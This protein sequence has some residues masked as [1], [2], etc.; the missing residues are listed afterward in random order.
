MSDTEI[1]SCML[2]SDVAMFPYPNNRGDEIMSFQSHDVKD[3]FFSFRDFC[4]LASLVNR[5]NCTNLVDSSFVI[6]SS[7]NQ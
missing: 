7:L 6:K 5:R 3:S 4:L 2:N 1:I